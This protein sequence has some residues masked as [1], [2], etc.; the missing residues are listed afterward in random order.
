MRNHHEMEVSC[1]KRTLT[2]D[3]HRESKIKSR[4]LEV[5]LT[6]KEGITNYLEQNI[7]GD[8][9][10][11]QS[12]DREKNKETKREI[13]KQNKEIEIERTQNSPRLE[14]E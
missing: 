10:E 6:I 2:L 13:E 9:S 11:I 7:N 3:G 5:T 1:L 14:I 4:R 8:D 12:Q